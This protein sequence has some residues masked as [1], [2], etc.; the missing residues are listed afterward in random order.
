MDRISTLLPQQV[1]TR[2]TTSGA[3]ANNREDIEKVAKEME[4]LFAYQMLKVM[5]ET[6]NSTGT[7]KSEY[8]NDIY[9]SMFDMEVSN[10]MA[11]RGMGLRD[12][13]VKSLEGM[14][15]EASEDSHNTNT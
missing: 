15:N 3:S 9:M 8:G 10:L 12:A 2:Q 11:D 6:S 4:S 1:Q 7:E 13:I 5:R 14:S